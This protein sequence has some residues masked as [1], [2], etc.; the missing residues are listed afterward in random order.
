MQQYTYDEL[1]HAAVV[2][3]LRDNLE[4]SKS[5]IELIK[6]I[7]NNNYKTL[8]HSLLD[9]FDYLGDLDREIKNVNITFRYLN[10]DLHITTKDDWYDF[11]QKLIDKFCLTFNVQ[12][13]ANNNIVYYYLPSKLDYIDS[14]I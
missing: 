13:I 4:Q 8:L 6:L 2:Y 12:G 1:R 3:F 14:Q 5:K 9:P 7:E 11:I 10:T